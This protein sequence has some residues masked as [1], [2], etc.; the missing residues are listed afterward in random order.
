LARNRGYA[1]GLIKHRSL[2]RRN[3]V[4]TDLVTIGTLAASALAMTSEEA[5][6]G[7]VG[8]AGKEAWKALTNKLAS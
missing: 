8:E 5:V 2:L 7:F 3:G 1:R 4:M 6:K